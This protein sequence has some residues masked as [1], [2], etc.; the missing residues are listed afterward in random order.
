MLHY[1]RMS[2]RLE[3]EILLPALKRYA[4]VLRRPCAKHYVRPLGA[5]IT[6]T[7]CQQETEVLSPLV[8]ET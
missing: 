5:K 1:I 7:N 6:L 2:F 8:S 4:V 3:E